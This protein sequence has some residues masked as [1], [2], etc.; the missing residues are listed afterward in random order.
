MVISLLPIRAWLINSIP[1]N[2]KL[3]M[4]AGI[5]FFLAFIAMKNAGIV[6]ANSATFVGLGDLV[7]FGPLLALVGF[8]AITAMAAMGYRSAVI[9][10]IVLISLIGW[11]SGQADFIGV[12][13]A[14]LPSTRND[15]IRHCSRARH[16]HAECGAHAIAGG[17]V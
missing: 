8:F 3:G 2:L 11:I 5:G 7:S 12:V 4:A 13:S 10:G 1:R 14:A 9:L 16:F 15:A 6:Q 17:C